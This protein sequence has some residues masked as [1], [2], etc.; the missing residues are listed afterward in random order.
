MNTKTMV[1][2][3]VGAT[4]VACAVGAFQSRP[5]STVSVTPL[6]DPS[7]NGNIRGIVRSRGSDEG[8]ANA[9]VVLQCTCLAGTRETQTNDDGVYAFRDLP[10]GNYTVQILAGANDVSYVLSLEPGTQ[11]RVVTRMSETEAMVVT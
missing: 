6:D 1:A 9:L 2:V 10:S 3:V 8:L 5:G 4:S 7:Q 11:V